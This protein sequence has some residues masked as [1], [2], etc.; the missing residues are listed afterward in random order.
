M[1]W[2]ADHLMVR[3]INQFVPHGFSPKEFPEPDCPPHFYA[4]GHNSQYPYFKTLM[5]CMNRVSMFL[6]NAKP[7]PQ[8]A[9]LYHPDAEWAGKAM[10][11][12]K[13]ARKLLEN[14]IDFDIIPCDYL[15][16]LLGQGG[17]LLD[18]ETHS[19]SYTVTP[20]F[21]QPNSTD[22]YL[23]MIVPYCEYIPLRAVRA[24]NRLLDDG[25]P[26]MFIIDYPSGV[27]EDAAVANHCIELEMLRRAE[28]FALDGLADKV[29]RVIIPDVSLANAHP[30]L[31][32]LALPTGS[33]SAVLFFNES[34]NEAVNDTAMLR[35]DMP[36]TV[37][38]RYHAV[39]NTA[40]KIHA[41]TIREQLRFPIDLEPG[42]AAVFVTD[43]SSDETL[44]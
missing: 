35:V 9:I 31:R 11:F 33:V 41:E 4:R 8:A 39:N 29:K 1:K 27:C 18:G 5:E 10:L 43:G 2:Q 16:N 13:P 28:L 40:Y 19:N 6:N 17:V 14:Q 34:V 44:E 21:V 12:Q 23:L 36:S 37:V 22:G 3:G 42:E 26:V 32:A 25:I 20:F 24:L 38:T 30:Y 7:K 15:G